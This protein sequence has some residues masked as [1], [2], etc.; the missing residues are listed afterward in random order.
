MARLATLHDCNIQ[1]ANIFSHRSR[2]KSKISHKTKQEIV[3]LSSKSCCWCRSGTKKKKKKVE[4]RTEHAVF[5]GNS[6]YVL[7]VSSRKKWLGAEP[8]PHTGKF[9]VYAL[10]YD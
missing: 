5:G 9:P 2:T 1:V 8:P 4:P 3:I 10:E 6:K 7:N